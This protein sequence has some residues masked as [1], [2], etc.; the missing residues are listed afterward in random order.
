MFTIND[1]ECLSLLGTEHFTNRAMKGSR[2]SLWY[3]HYTQMLH[4]TVDAAPA[5]D[6]S[7]TKIASLFLLELREWSVQFPVKTD[8]LHVSRRERRKSSPRIRTVLLRCKY[9]R[10]QSFES[11]PSLNRKPLLTVILG[12]TGTEPNVTDIPPSR[13]CSGMRR[14]RKTDNRFKNGSHT[15]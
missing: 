5:H 6:A 11:D 2:T 12:W 1:T 15:D 4:Y 14:W 10:R 7:P 13:N 8:P 9:R 3:L